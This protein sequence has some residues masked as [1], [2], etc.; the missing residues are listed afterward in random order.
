MEREKAIVI[1]WSGFLTH[2]DLDRSENA[3]LLSK[4]G[5]YLWIYNGRIIYVGKADC[6]R[7]RFLQHICN[8]IGGRSLILDCHDGDPYD[9]LCEGRLASARDEKKVFVPFDKF[10]DF[11]D[12]WR[13]ERSLEFISHCKFTFGVMDGV[14]NSLF[15]EVEGGIIKWLGEKYK[16][17]R[18]PTGRAN[19]WIIGAV[20][21]YPTTK[22]SLQHV[23]LGLRGSLP[24]LPDK[25]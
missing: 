19:H 17:A 21:K 10:S 4:G 6:F 18:T 20:S 8:V 3:G 12:T 7:D 9:V 23:Y 22:Y 24:S 16:L 1:N 2:L 11:W 14:E 15:S 13:I 5:I 25:I